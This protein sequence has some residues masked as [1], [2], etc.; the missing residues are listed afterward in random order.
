M[1]RKPSR[2]KLLPRAGVLMGLD[3]CRNVID[4]TDGLGVWISGEAVGDNMVFHFPGRLSS[5]FLP[6][7]GFACGALKTTVLIAIV[8]HGHQAQQMVHVATLAKFAH[9]LW[10]DAFVLQDAFISR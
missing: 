8:V 9:Q 3:A 10:L 7:D 4:D 6:I 2:T 1:S 5:C